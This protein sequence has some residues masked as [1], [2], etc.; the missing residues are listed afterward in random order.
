MSEST[1]T[2][3]CGGGFAVVLDNEGKLIVSFAYI[4]R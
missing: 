3:P 4:C 1:D 2:A